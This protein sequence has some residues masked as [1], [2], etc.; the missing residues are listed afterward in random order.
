MQK[1]AGLKKGRWENL[2]NKTL[3]IDTSEGSF[4]FRVGFFDS[5]LLILKVDG[6]NE[7]AFFVNESKYVQALN[8]P[9]KILE[10]LDDVYVKQIKRINPPMPKEDNSL[11]G[12]G[13]AEIPAFQTLRNDEG[14]Y[15]FLGENNKLIT[16]YIYDYAYDF[17]EDLALIGIRNHYGFINKKG[18]EVIPRKFEYAESFSENLALVRMNRKFGYINKLGEVVI[19]FKFD[20]GESFSNGRAKVRKGNSSFFID[21]N[22]YRV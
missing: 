20:S 2:G 15:A 12:S 3:L 18:E 6:I 19:D 4:L 5:H 16:D 13:R 1:T 14:K 17:Q 11:I 7:Y 21:K 10:H 22:G 9:N 8:S